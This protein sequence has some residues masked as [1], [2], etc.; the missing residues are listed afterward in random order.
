MATIAVSSNTASVRSASRL[1]A[2]ANSSSSVFPK[3]TPVAWRKSA[4][5]ASVTGRSVRSIRGVCQLAWVSRL[6]ILHAASMLFACYHGGV[7][8]IQVKNVPEDLHAALRERAAAEGKTIG[9]VILE[10]LRRDLRRQTMRAW[11][12]SL[13][14]M[15]RPWPRPTREQMEEIMREAD[16][17]TWGPE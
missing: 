3:A 17:D 14:K 15:D 4:S 2:H 9:E 1:G 7:S 16:E 13:A 8:A 11:L 10:L 5:S 6:W 12:D